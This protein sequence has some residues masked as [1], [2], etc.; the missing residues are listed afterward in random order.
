VWQV[1]AQHHQDA[2][3]TP[4]PLR[5]ICT[6]VGLGK[7]AVLNHL[8][9]LFEHSRIDADRRTPLPGADV[10]PRQVSTPTPTAAEWAATVQAPDPTC[11]RLIVVLAV[12]VDPGTPWSGRMSIPEIA[13]RAGVST[14]TASTHRAHLVAARLARF[15]AEMDG[16]GARQRRGPDRYYLLSGIIVPPVPEGARDLSWE[17]GRAQQLLSALP[18]WTRTTAAE[19]AAARRLLAARFRDGWPDAALLALLTDATDTDTTAHTPPGLLRW[20]LRRAAG[21]YVLP[22]H[23]HA[24]GQ[25][26]RS[27]CAGCGRPFKRHRPAGEVCAECAEDPLVIA[28]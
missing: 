4:L 28:V 18:W 1:L 17:D 23:Q 10:G 22:A 7:G 14:R 6:A 15:Q 24:T 3:R 19:N 5:E 9:H 21:P 20:R 13:R 26:P 16:E 25:Q 12:A 27:R 11:A 8:T 2:P